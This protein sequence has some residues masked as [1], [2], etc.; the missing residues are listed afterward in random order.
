ML[1]QVIKIKQRCSTEAENKGFKRNMVLHDCKSAFINSADC[2]KL[3]QLKSM[4]IKIVKF[5][6]V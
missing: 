3:L 6:D 1:L 2:I 4:L 5:I